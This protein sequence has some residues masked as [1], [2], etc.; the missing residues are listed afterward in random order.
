MLLYPLICLLLVLAAGYCLALVRNDVLHKTG[1]VVLIGLIVI[2][3][4]ALNRG[5]AEIYYGRWSSLFFLYAVLPM[6]MGAVLLSPLRHALQTSFSAAEI[7][8]R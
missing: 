3:Q 7:C 1:A 5:V 8:T 4:V 2:L 6:S